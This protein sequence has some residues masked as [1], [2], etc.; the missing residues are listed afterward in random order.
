MQT[1]CPPSTSPTLTIG[2]IHQLHGRSIAAHGHRNACR[3]QQGGLTRHHAVGGMPLSRIHHFQQRCPSNRSFQP[4]MSTFV[5][6]SWHLDLL[7]FFLFP[8]QRLA[9][10][11]V[12]KRTW[13]GGHVGIEIH[14]FDRW[15]PCTESRGPVGACH[16]SHG[17]ELAAWA[18]VRT[19]F[20]GPGTRGWNDVGRSI[21]WKD[22]P[23]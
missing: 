22:D 16:V 4:A 23:R 14:P 6:K 12:P 5:S 10:A 8:V 3:S 19:A 18:E 2:N 11:T 9:V 1:L 17:S 15:D 21:T 7:F 13:T 20:R